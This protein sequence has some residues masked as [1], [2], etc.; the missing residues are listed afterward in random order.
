VEKS[1]TPNPKKNPKWP[2][3]TSA[4]KSGVYFPFLGVW[5]LAFVICLRQQAV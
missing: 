2:P 1:Q 5:T 4:P 3:T